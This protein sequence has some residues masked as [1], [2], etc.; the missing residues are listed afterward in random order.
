VALIVPRVDPLEITKLAGVP[1]TVVI[2]PLVSA[3]ERKSRVHEDRETVKA[4]EATEAV[5]ENI[6]SKAFVNVGLP[7]TVKPPVIVGDVIVGDVIVG[8]AMFGCG[9]YVPTGIAVTVVDVLKP[10]CLTC[11][12]ESA[13]G[14][15]VNVIVVPDVV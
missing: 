10:K 9:I 13:G 6:L 14:A 11:T 5:I 4:L 3:L 8:D 12:L 7:V 15:E 2:V 1:E